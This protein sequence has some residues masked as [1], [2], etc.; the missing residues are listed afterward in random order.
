MPEIDVGEIQARLGETYKRRYDRAKELRAVTRSLQKT[1]RPAAG[2]A[3]SQNQR[4]LSRALQ[5]HMPDA[6][7]YFASVG[8]DFQ[9]GA[10]GRHKAMQRL[11]ALATPLV[12]TQVSLDT[13]FLIWALRNGG[14]ATQM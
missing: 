11:G 8:R 2:D 9:Q 3:R 6:A 5:Q 7:E 13:A 1:R 14:Q 4:D 10:D 12:P